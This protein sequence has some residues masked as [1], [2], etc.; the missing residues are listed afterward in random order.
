MIVIFLLFLSLSFLLAI[1]KP[2]YY[3]IFYL[4]A[5]TKF[6]GFFDI[7]EAFIIGGTGLGFPMLN[8]IT[9]ITVFFST[10]WHKITKEH[11]YFIL[12]FLLI[13]IGGIIYPI[14]LGLESLQQA[15]I[16]SKELWVIFFFIYLVSYKNS[17]NI[18]L[19]LK[20]IK[21][22]GL[23]ISLVYIIYI[24]TGFAPPS[25]I[26]ENYVKAFFP[27]F[28][29]LSLF[30]YFVDYQENKISKIKFLYIF[31][32]LITGIILALHLSLV[33]GTVFSLF[34]INFLYKN[35]KFSFSNFLTKLIIFLSIL[36]I[37]LVSSQNLRYNV[38][39]TIEA[40]IYGKDSALSSRDIY[41]EFRWKAI[42][43]RPYFGYGFIHKSAP[44]TKKFNKI[45][46]NR[47]AESFG[48]ID[49]GYV[50]MLIKFGYLGTF[51][52]L[53]LWG[54]YILKPLFNPTKNTFIQLA[55]AA[56]ILQYYLISYTW[57]VFTFSHGLIPA[58]IALFLITTKDER[59]KDKF[60]N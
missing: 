27:T 58:F 33:I 23:Y 21:L 8:I 56:Y 1:K 52:Y 9:I 29:S 13:L 18:D 42:E 14:Y 44:I 19:I 50:D 6:L 36:F 57:S 12:F 15:I 34:L 60:Q 10:N 25:Y 20:S 5:N 4:L 40:I 41:N 3:V 38:F 53:L 31:L 46:N 54:K 43:K 48:V 55:M 11:L 59:I 39:S 2:T 22:I 7:S 35:N 30:I 26:I 45:K 32:F 51:F 24:I 49:S 37:I 47:F 16:S 17:L 28:M